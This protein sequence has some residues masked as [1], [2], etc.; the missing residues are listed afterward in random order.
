LE[1]Y[2][3]VFWFLWIEFCIVALIGF[4]SQD[5]GFVRE[6]RTRVIF[7]KKLEKKKIIHF[8]MV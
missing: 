5:F 4:E 3:I 8:C 1:K 6:T 2:I 7:L